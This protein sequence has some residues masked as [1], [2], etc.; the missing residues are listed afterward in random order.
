MP[1]TKKKKHSTGFLEFQ[2]SYKKKDVSMFLTFKNLKSY[3][4]I[5]FVL[6]TIKSCHHLS[7]YLV[8]IQKNVLINV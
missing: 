5:W 1:L 4:L 8:Y 6:I 7:F 3:V 2:C